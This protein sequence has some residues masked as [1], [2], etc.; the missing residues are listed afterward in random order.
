MRLAATC[1]WSGQRVRRSSK[2]ETVRAPKPNLLLVF[3][4]QMRGMAMGCAGNADVKTPVMDRLAA[5][6][7]RL[8]N[9]IASVPVCGPN[10]ACLLTGS[11]PTTHRVL[12]NDLALPTS[13]ETLGTLAK[14]HGYRTGYVGK[15]HL[16]GVPRG[17]FTPPGPRRFGFDFWAVYNCTHDYLHPKFYRDTPDLLEPKGYEPEVQTDLGLEFLEAQKGADSPFCLVLSWG[18]PHDPYDAVPEPYRRLYAGHA[19][20]APER[21]GGHRQ[22]GSRKPRLPP[23]HRRLLRRHHCPGRSVGQAVGKAGRTRP[24]R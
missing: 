4:D 17:K 10:R 22:P 5:E 18:P 19:H 21:S 16:D 15:W 2:D 24:R 20:I 9:C 14:A 8:T 12:A 11:Y 7:V 6:G 3:A 13:T 1:P 23:H